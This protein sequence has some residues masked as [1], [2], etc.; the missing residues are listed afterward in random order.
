MPQLD[1]S[2]FPSQLFW[3]SICFFTM[4]FLMRKII[5]P[6]IAEM[7]NLRKEKIDDYLQKAAEIKEKAEK[8][9]EKYQEALQKATSEANQSLLKTQQD[10]KNLMECKQADLSAELAN[11]IKEGEQKIAQGKQKALKQVEEMSAELAM[12]VIKK[13]GLKV[14]EAQIRKAIDVSVKE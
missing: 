13:L 3:L 7:I 10:L 8:S 5:I 2:V 9:L 1:F 4:L 12:D 6:R 14:S 11:Q